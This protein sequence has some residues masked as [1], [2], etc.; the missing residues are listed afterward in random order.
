MQGGELLQEVKDLQFEEGFD[1]AE[2]TLQP[3]LFRFRALCSYPA[4][5]WLQNEAPQ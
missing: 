1:S 5:Q 3:F 4:P 2:T